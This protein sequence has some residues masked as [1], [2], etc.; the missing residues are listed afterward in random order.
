MSV[1]VFAIVAIVIIIAWRRLPLAVI[2]FCIFLGLFLLLQF[3]HVVVYVLKT[4]VQ[5]LKEVFTGGTVGQTTTV[6]T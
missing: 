5:Y 2:V 4:C 6:T 3:M 1:S